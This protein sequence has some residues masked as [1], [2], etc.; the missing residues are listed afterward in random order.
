VSTVTALPL[1]PP[2]PKCLV[3]SD[4]SEEAGYAP[5][6]EAGGYVLRMRG[7]EWFEHRCFKAATPT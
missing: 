7:P 4:S 2:W 3:V 6:L 5:V 1:P